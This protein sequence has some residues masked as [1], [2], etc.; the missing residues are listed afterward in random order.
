MRNKKTELSIDE[1]RKIAERNIRTYNG[2]V[3]DSLTDMQIAKDNSRLIKKEKH[4]RK[5][6]NRHVVGC[7]VFS[8]LIIVLIPT[9]IG[10]FIAFGISLYCGIRALE[11][12]TD[13]KYLVIIGF[14]LDCAFLLLP[15]L[16]DLIN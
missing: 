15:F 9:V 14:V 3:Y 5:Y 10:A 12:K 8:L 11:E 6:I 13:K 1:E 7:L 4:R 2:I 16:Y